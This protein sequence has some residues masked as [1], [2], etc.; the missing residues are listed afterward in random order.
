LFELLIIVG[1]ALVGACIIESAGEKAKETASHIKDEYLQALLQTRDTGHSLIG[2]VVVGIVVIVAAIGVTVWIVRAPV[3]A[4]VP[5][6]A[7][8]VAPARSAPPASE[9]VRPPIN[10]DWTVPAWLERP[11]ERVDGQ[12]E[13]G[14]PTRAP[15]GGTSL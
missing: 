9:D 1:S 10:R 3:T 7:A 6:P 11:P 12:P 15:A 2:W 14:V 13:L 5:V 4:Q 8:Q